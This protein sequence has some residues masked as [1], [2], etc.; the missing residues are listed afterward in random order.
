M[1]LLIEWLLTVLLY[2]SALKNPFARAAGSSFLEHSGAC[3][4]SINGINLIWI[5]PG[6][7]WGKFAIEVSGRMV[8]SVGEFSGW[9]YNRGI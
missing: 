2:L 9:E 8:V 5:C 6:L 1:S 3:F 4:Y 7:I